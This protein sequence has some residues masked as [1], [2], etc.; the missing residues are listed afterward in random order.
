MDKL[1]ESRF[2]C[3][4]DVIPMKNE[5][6]FGTLLFSS[7]TTLYIFL[8]SGCCLDCLAVLEHGKD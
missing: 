3:V 5:R 7:A 4:Y 1:Q 6:F 2:E 8:F